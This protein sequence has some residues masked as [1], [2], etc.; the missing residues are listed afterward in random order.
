MKWISVVSYSADSVSVLYDTA[1]I[2]NQRC[3]IQRWYTFE[4]E[5]LCEIET[6]FENIWGCESGTPIE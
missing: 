3:I 1:L 4:Y 2:P 5:Y 6:E